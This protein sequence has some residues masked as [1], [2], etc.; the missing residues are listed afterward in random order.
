[1]QKCVFCRKGPKLFIKYEK[2]LPKNDTWS[3]TLYFH[4]RLSTN[5]D[6]LLARGLLFGGIV[7]IE[8]ESPQIS[9]S[10]SKSQ[11]GAL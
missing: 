1:M 3:V 7:I 2:R 5:D 10:S 8:K 6:I 11:E 9:Q 4:P